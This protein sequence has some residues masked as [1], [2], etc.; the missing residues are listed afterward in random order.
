[1]RSVKKR[2][3]K[4]RKKAKNILQKMMAGRGTW[5]ASNLVTKK[6]TV[7]HN[8]PAVAIIRYPFVLLSKGGSLLNNF[9]AIFIAFSKVY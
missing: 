9:Q 3:I 1:V 4:R 6:P 5:A 8:M 2:K 7:P